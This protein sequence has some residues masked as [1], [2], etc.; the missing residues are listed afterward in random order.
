MAGFMN[1]PGPD[2]VFVRESSPPSVAAMNRVEQAER[3]ES[4]GAL[5]EAVEHWHRAVELQPQNAF[6][7]FKLGCCLWQ[8]DMSLAEPALDACREAVRLD[9]KF[10]NA[11]NEIGLIISNLGRHGDAEAAFAEAEP[12]HGTQAHHWCAR[13]RNYICLDRL[14]EAADAFKRAIDLTA[15]RAHVL[16]MTLRAATMMALGDK[17]G[18]KRLGKKVH[19]LTGRD[20]STDWEEILDS[21]RSNSS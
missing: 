19:F 18:A 11:R 8:L 6:F 20:P 17:Q 4:I 7:Y 3:A 2:M 14:E 5:D 16:A 15:Q 21:V 1:Q 13:G 9:P 10:G 12:Y